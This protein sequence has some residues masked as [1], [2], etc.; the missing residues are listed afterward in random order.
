MTLYDFISIFDESDEENRRIDQ[1]IK[2]AKYAVKNN[3]PIEEVTLQESTR[4]VEQTDE[5][6]PLNDF[7]IPLP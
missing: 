4:L 5:D 1:S 7:S 3:V 2:V 6:E